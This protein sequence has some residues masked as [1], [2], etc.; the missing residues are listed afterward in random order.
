M[1]N[2]IENRSNSA[3][4]ECCRPSAAVCQHY[5]A[6]SKRATRVDNNYVFH[7]SRCALTSSLRRR[8]LWPVC[9]GISCGA[10][11]IGC[12]CG[13]RWWRRGVL[14]A[15]IRRGGADEVDDALHLLFELLRSDF[16]ITGG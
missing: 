1:A 3:Q 14:L 6:G 4:L 13:L 5:N 16:L 15:D 9:V 8:R 12:R 10:V 11:G 7:H 2:A